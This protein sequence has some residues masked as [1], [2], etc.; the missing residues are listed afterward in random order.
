MYVKVKVSFFKIKHSSAA[1]AEKA[2]EA[3]AIQLPEALKV[4]ELQDGAGTPAGA[5]PRLVITVI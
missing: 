1:E 2:A 3:E 4:H 5:W